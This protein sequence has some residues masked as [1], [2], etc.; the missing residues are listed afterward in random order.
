MIEGDTAH[1]PE[2][3]VVPGGESNSPQDPRVGGF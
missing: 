3:K 1:K 2:L